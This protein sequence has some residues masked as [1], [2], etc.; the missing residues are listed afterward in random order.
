MLIFNFHHV[1]PTPLH[2]CRKHITITPEGLRRFIQVIRSLGLKP[3][4]LR[5]VIASEGPTDASHKDVILTFDDGYEN[6]FLHA[7]PILEAE[8]CPATVF[9]LANKFA[10]TNDWDQ[11]EQPECQRDKLLSL[12]Q[13]QLL[14]SSPYF[15][16]G[17]HGLEHRNFSQLPAD[18]LHQE[19][20]ESYNILSASLKE[21]FVPVLSYP[22]GL[23]S[24]EVRDMLITSPY[25]FGFTTQ[26]GIWQPETLPYDI[27]RYSVYNR[28]ANPFILLAKLVRNGL[29]STVLA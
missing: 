28:D 15:T 17:S 25:R 21:A 19:V 11:G 3:V 10:G 20:S 16:F 1:E 22:W 4:S 26:K 12:E 18:A 13:M 14:S 7:K 29:L 2:L 24:N 27:P 9:V 23:Y 6:F 8:E 5:D